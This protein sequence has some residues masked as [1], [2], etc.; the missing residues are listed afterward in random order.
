MCQVK[1]D[2]C[3]QFHN[4]TRWAELINET[5]H[6]VL[7]E[8]CHQGAYTPGMGQ[9]QGYLKS[10][11]NYSHFLGMFFGMGSATVVPNVSFDACRSKC[12]ALGK[13]CGGFC[14]KSRDPVPRGMIEQCYIQAR[15]VPNH[16]DMSNTNFCDGSSS[17]SDCP[18]NLY[19]VSGDISA[20]WRAMLANLEYT[21]PFLGEGGVHPPYPQ[22]HTIRS[23]PGGWSY[24]DMLEV[25]NLA[26][27][28]EDRSH[29]AAWAI[30]SSPLILSFNLTDPRRMDRSWP[31]IS[32]RAIIEVNQRWA[33]DPGRR[34]V[35]SEDGWQ[36]WAKPMSVD[37]FAVLLLNTGSVAAQT[38][39]TLYNVSAKLPPRAGVCAKDL[40]TGKTMAPL[41]PGA[42][43][44]AAL[45]AHD[46]GLYCVWPEDSKH[47][48]SGPSAASCP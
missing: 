48:C 28:T 5:G 3:S 30:I 35:V 41:A 47:G 2:S 38:S 15:A 23:R 45:P 12:D 13:G 37:A 16:M 43:L 33:G 9:W 8:N 21:L 17:P 46:S 36:A 11:V 19:R 25:G 1:F 29:F 42:P 34:I 14:F 40:Y 24:P 39:L 7:I 4:L 22:D 10:G 31:I 27:A 26:N 18:Y 20:S 6:P 32:N 44:E